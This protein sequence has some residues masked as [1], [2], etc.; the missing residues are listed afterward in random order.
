[1]S[2]WPGNIHLKGDKSGCVEEINN[3][4]KIEIDRPN[5]CPQ[6]DQHPEKP[7]LLYIL[8]FTTLA[9][10]CVKRCAIFTGRNKQKHDLQH[11]AK[12]QYSSERD[13]SIILGKE[14][15]TCVSMTVHPWQ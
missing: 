1:M 7:G 11:N 4:G 10:W 12:I 13:H 14:Q 2:C 3:E 8:R 15:Y 5:E 9:K 6:D